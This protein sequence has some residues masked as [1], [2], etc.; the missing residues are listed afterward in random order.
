VALAPESER[1]YDR[2]FEVV[3]QYDAIGKL[4][5]KPKSRVISASLF[6]TPK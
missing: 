6:V 4:E 3:D 1:R 2:A 5:I